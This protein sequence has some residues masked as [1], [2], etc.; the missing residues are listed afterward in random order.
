MTDRFRQALRDLGVPDDAELG[1]AVSGGPD[2]LALLLLAHAERPGRVK[3]A[4]VDH[5]LRPESRAEAA[6][7]AE[8][9]AARSIPHATL[10]VQ[11]PGSGQAAARAARYAALARWCSDDGLN[12]LA[13]GHHADDQAETIVMRLNRGSGLAGLA[14]VR[15]GRRLSSGVTLVR[16]LLAYLRDALALVVAGAGLQP[17]Q[18][19]SN[20]DPRHDRTAA[21]ALLARGGLDPERIARS[22]AHLAEAEE[23]LAWAADRLAAERIDG[24]SLDPE[25]IPPE[26]LR[27]LVHRML[28][29]R[30]ASP[31]GPQLSRFVACLQAGRSAT[32]GPVLARPGHRWHFEAAPARRRTADRG[33]AIAG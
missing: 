21:R 20:K 30:G 16:P 12:W 5:Q 22:A 15:A 32:L 18:D 9:C 14:G 19:P 4:T 24:V 29:M 23:A 28:E 7:V 26:L 17:V 27:R 6:Y 13:T 10:A 11:V 1:I 3:A 31:S 33:A 25:G 8:V 2:S